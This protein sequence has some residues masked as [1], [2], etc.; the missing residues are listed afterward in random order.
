MATAKALE[1]ET[2]RARKEE[3]DRNKFQGV[4]W[5][6]NS[7]LKLQRDERDQSRVQC[8]ILKDELKAY[9]RSKRR[10]SQQL[11]ET[12]GNMLAIVDKY[13]EE[14]NLAV[15]HEHRL[16]DEYAKV[17]VVKEARGRVTNSLHGEVMM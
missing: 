16:V 1:R 12:E 9:L 2:K 3:H 14:L 4:V 7:E 15:A 13:K 10:L 5:G 8:M 6:R 17:S 11:S